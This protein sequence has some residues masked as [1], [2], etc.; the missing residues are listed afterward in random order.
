MPV[1]IGRRDPSTAPHTKRVIT[2]Q[3]PTCHGVT[4]RAVSWWKWCE[5]ILWR[6][7][8]CDVWAEEARREERREVLIGAFEGTVYHYSIDDR[9]CISFY[10][11]QSPRQAGSPLKTGV[12]LK[13]HILR[14]NILYK[15]THRNVRYPVPSPGLV[16]E[17]ASPIDVITSAI[18]KLNRIESYVSKH[19]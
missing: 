5:V 15:L 3:V 1:N 4:E 2:F 9:G 18:S 11:I 16:G 12:K 17:I 8:E 7:S 19:W 6:R 13:S 10:T 14:N